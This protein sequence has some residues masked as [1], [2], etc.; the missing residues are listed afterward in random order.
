MKGTG[1]GARGVCEVGEEEREVGE[2]VREKCEVEN[3][4]WEKMGMGGWVGVDN[5]NVEFIICFSNPLFKQRLK[6]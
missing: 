3:V 2:N 1:E 4:R 6:Y 5:C